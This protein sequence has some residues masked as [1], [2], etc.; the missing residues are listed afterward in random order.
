MIPDHA[1][2]ILA[3]DAQ[4]YIKRLHGWPYAGVA[5]QADEW[6][7]RKYLFAKEVWSRRDEI[8]S[9]FKDKNGNPITWA[10][11]FTDMF[12]ESLEDYRAR[13]RAAQTQVAA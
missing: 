3:E 2:P 10:A 12:F 7:R 11:R 1:K 5:P 13:I 9:D 6:A 4:A 8:C